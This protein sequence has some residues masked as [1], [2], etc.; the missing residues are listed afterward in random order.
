VPPALLAEA[1]SELGVDELVEALA[2]VANE[3]GTGVIHIEQRPTEFAALSCGF[4]VIPDTGIRTL[5]PDRGPG[6]ET[7]LLGLEDDRRGLIVEQGKPLPGRVPVRLDQGFV[8]EAG[9][10]GLVLGT[11]PQGFH[12]TRLWRQPHGEPPTTLRRDG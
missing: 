4:D 1:V 6:H 10:G 3:R 11:C 8:N 12:V 9:W 5:S 7:R 2:H